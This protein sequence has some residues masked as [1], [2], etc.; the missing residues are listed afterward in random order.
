MPEY[1]KSQL[2]TSATLTEEKLTLDEQ[3]LKKSHKKM[4]FGEILK[5][6][7]F[8]RN[9]KNISNLVKEMIEAI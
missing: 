9:K 7:G 8:Y 1:P 4:S 5:S 2:R 3:A 6:G